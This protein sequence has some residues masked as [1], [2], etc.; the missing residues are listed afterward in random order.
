[1]VEP[2]A[3]IGAIISVLNFG[4][5]IFEKVKSKRAGEGQKRFEA[6]NAMLEALLQTRQRLENLPPDQEEPEADP[7]L[8]RLWRETANKVRSVDPSLANTML[9]KAEYWMNP[10]AWRGT[11]AEDAKISLSNIQEEL[12]KMRDD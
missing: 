7:E 1:M 5:S 12:T 6:R 4:I 2:I 9:M 11:A 3:A 8:V 10:R